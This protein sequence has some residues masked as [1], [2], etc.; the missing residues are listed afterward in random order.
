MSTLHVLYNKH[1]STCRS[2]FYKD[3]L[4]PPIHPAVSYRRSLAL[5][6]SLH[7]LLAVIALSLARPRGRATWS[8]GRSGMAV[9]L[10]WDDFSMGKGG[11]VWKLSIL[12]RSRSFA[13]C[14]SLAILFVRRQIKANKEEQVRAN[15]PHPSKGCEFLTCTGIVMREPAEI[16]RSEILPRRVVDES[17]SLLAMFYYIQVERWTMVEF[18]V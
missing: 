6:M 13:S 11:N 14:R 12:Q 18:V 8:R 4:S 16:A 5:L 2:Q 15:N 7:G 17:S 9:R 3:R 10:L 1:A